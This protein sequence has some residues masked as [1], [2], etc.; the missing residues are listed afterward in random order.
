MMT[1]PALD[2]LLAATLTS[3]LLLSL[4]LLLRRPVGTNLGART[5]YLLWLAVP[6][7]LLVSLPWISSHASPVRV[8]LPSVIAMPAAG[9]IPA[10][11]AGSGLVHWLTLLWLTGA[12]LLLV[13]L[14]IQAVRSSRMASADAAW[15]PVGG[16]QHPH[17]ADGR[18]RVSRQVRSPVVAGLLRPKVL[19]PPD[20]DQRL[21]YASLELVLRHE[22]CHARRRDNLVNLLAGAVLAVFW[23][24]PMAWLAYRAFRTDQELSCDAHALNDADEFQRAR[25]GRAIL[26]LISPTDPGP[27]T[28]AWHLQHSTR[29]RITMLKQ[30]HHSR[31]RTLAGTT[32]VCALA[33]LSISIAPT[34]GAA[35]STDE[36]PIDENPRPIVRINPGYPVEAVQQKL[37]GFVTMEFTITEDAGVEDIVVLD[38]QPGSVF[39]EAAVSALSKWRFAP[40]KF[41]GV[42]APRRAVQTIEFRLDPETAE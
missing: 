38:S 40:E 31:L 17:A 39:D 16:R 15:P 5:A 14:A 24:N 2:W 8:V 11:P 28:T 37:E 23:F 4:I 1:I 20:I 10:A 21:D 29:R 7:Q 12:A 13:R 36:A 3:S 35:P 34:T 33:V 9:G 27:L 22:T 30:H 19:L 32:L 25:Y 18:T 41:D 42:R 26:D 6:M